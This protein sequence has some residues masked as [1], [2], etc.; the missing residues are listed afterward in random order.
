MSNFKCIVCGGTDLRM[1]E[2]VEQ[3]YIVSQLSIDDSG[4]PCF[5]EGEL[6]ETHYNQQDIQEFI[7]KDCN[8]PI[9]NSNIKDCIPEKR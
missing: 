2:K 6:V 4:N 1:F 3:E 8:L 5:E 7:C 9:N